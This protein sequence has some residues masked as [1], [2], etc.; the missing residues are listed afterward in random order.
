MAKTFEYTT[1]VEGGVDI[2][3]NS[4]GWWFL[5]LS[6]DTTYQY[7]DTYDTRHSLVDAWNDSKLRFGVAKQS[8]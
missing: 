5:R 2:A 8:R 6:T 7:S 1:F 3:R 4:S